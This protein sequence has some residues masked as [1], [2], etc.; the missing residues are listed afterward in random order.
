MLA[1]LA[2]WPASAKIFLKADG[3]VLGPGD[4]LV[5]QD[6]ADTLETIAR[7]GW[8]AFYEGPIAEKIA[9]AVASAGGIMTADDLKDYRAI[10]RMPVKGRARV[11]ILH[12]VAPDLAASISERVRTA[13]DPVFEIT[14]DIGPTV[15]T[16][17]GPGAVGV[18]FIP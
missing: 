1:R 13:A 8:R 10:E 6:L 16:H 5:Q 2:R 12:S 11:A 9:A 3:S 7:D 18:C 14:C 15:G 17:A 4:R